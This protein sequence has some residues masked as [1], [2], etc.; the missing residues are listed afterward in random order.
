MMGRGVIL[1]IIL[2]IG[3][4]S[5]AQD[6]CATPPQQFLK[7]QRFE[8]WMQTKQFQKS[9][10][11]RTERLQAEVYVL[12]VVIHIIHNGEAVG[13]GGNLSEAKIQEQI[14]ILNEDFRK[15]NPRAGAGVPVE[16]QPV[17]ADIEVEFVLA[18]Q[19]PDGKPTTGILRKQGAQSSYSLYSD[20]KK[21]KEESYWPAEDY[22]NIWVAETGI[23]YGL[24]T[25]PES[26]EYDDITGSEI[27]RLYDGIV[28]DDDYVGVNFDADNSFVSYGQ[29]ASHEIGHFLGLHHIWGGDGGCSSSDYCDDTPP[30]ID[31]HGGEGSPC[32]FPIVDVLETEGFDEGNTCTNDDPDLP[33]MFMNFMDYSNDECMNMFTSDQRTRIRTVLENSPRRLSLRTSH[34]L[35][36]PFAWDLDLAISEIADVPLITCSTQI[37]PS[38]SLGN[39]GFDEITSYKMSYTM[40]G[41]S[42]EIDN[43][44][45][46]ILTGESYTFQV[47]IDGLSLGSNEI[48][49]EILEVNGST[50]EDATN[51]LGMS[52]VEVQTET[53]QAPFKEDF[54]SSMWNQVSPQTN[55]WSDFSINSDASQ[56]VAAFENDTD[57]VSWLV[58]PVFDLSD[59]EE[60]GVFFRMSY[61][62]RFG[63]SDGLEVKISTS[64]SDDFQTIW[65]QGLGDLSFPSSSSAWTPSDDTDWL[66]R[67]ISLDDYIGFEEVRLAFAFTNNGGNNFYID[68]IELTNNSD[69]D[70]PRLLAGNFVA[71]PNPA[72]QS[73][74]ITLSLPEAQPIRV[75]LID[76]SGAMVNDLR[77]DDVLNQTFLVETSDIFGMYFLKIT[78]KDI[79]QT[80]RMLISR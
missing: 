51:D 64:C 47:V 6:R 26:D 1:M 29:T 68:D 61:G 75:Q 53:F 37:S 27:N 67:F 80:Q 66:D 65:S 50:D 74:N 5:R 19:D 44:N 18:K 49:W 10:Q 9:L 60:A 24:A 33:D 23:F 77:Y 4:M 15:M 76:I 55:E 8:N 62:I 41:I 42:T 43:P 34:G 54:S 72:S 13:V 31:D 21:L 40:G 17:E 3:V 57:A 39:F 58:S 14:D 30:A 36:P 32:T 69:P 78:G 20:D 59:F 38:I 35:E 71:Y 56:R 7:S 79:N 73:F 12:P 16:F 46:S 28:I 70:Q 48:S 22:I 45:I 52:I 63:F 2:T 11:L 25:F